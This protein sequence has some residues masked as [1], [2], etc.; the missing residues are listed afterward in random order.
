MIARDK[1]FHLVGGAGIGIALGLI[2]PGAGV[3]GAFLIGLGWEI[4]GAWRNRKRAKAG[5]PPS[6]TTE[7]GDVVWT[8]IGGAIGDVAVGAGRYILG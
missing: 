7:P 4:Y 6:Y 8:T 1:Q 2:Q 3:F 5:L